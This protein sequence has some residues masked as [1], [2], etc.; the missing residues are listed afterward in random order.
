MP[1]RGDIHQSTTDPGTSCVSLQGFGCK[2][3]VGPNNDIKREM[4]SYWGSMHVLPNGEVRYN[5][6]AIKSL[7]IA[8]RALLLDDEETEKP[9]M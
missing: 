2:E 7:Q 8:K 5:P 9:E 1:F 4:G 6:T 3:V